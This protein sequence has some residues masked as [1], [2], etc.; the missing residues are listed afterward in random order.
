MSK[1]TA[2]GFFTSKNGLVDSGEIDG[3][4]Y[5]ILK[6]PAMSYG[7]GG[8]N[9]YVLFPKRLTVEQGY[10]GILTYVPVHGGIT[11]AEDFA[12]GMVYGFDTAHSGSEKLPRTSIEWIKG[13]IAILINGI[14]QAAKIEAKYLTA[15]KDTTR[16]KYAQ[17]VQDVDTTGNERSFSVNINLLSGQI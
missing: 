3:H 15:K 14:N 6:G 8:Y 17:T 2:K 12:E 10:D 1:Q 16:A 5:W 4:K 7:M 13:Q 11:Y 9:G